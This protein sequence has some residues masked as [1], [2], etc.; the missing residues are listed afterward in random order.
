MRHIYIKPRTSRLKGKV[1]R[2]H[3]RDQEAFYPLISYQ[4]NP[5]LNQ[6]RAKWEIVYNG[7]QPQR[8]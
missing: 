7:H 2:S 8:G 1:E 6:K 4:G 5:D 3:Q